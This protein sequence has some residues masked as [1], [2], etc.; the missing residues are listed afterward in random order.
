MSSSRTLRIATTIVLLMA[1]CGS[2]HVVPKPVSPSASPTANQTTIPRKDAFFGLHFDLHATKTDT[3][4]GADTSE[5]NIGRLLDRVRPDFVEYDCKGHAGYTGYP[6]KVGWASPGIVK[7]A[8]AIWRK[9][10]RERH[11]GLYIH[12]SGVWD[13]Q[14]VEEHPEW[15][16][17]DEN[18][19][20]DGKATSTF[21]RYVD[22]LLI[23]QLT[24]IVKAYDIDGA[25]VDGD[26]W[27][28][29]W[30]WSK[31]A[32]EAWSQ[33]SGGKPVPHGNKDPGWDEF[34]TMQRAQFERYL[35]HWIDAIHAVKP[36][37]QLTSNWM[38]SSF[39]PSPIK[40]KVDF[41][42][43]DYTPDASLDSARFEGRYLAS[44]HMPWDLMDWGF[45][46][47][48]WNEL[49]HWSRK[50]AV[51]IEQDLSAVLMQGGG[52][53]I[54]YQP[55]RSGYV[56]DGIID[57]ASEVAGFCRARQAVSHKSTTV[58]QVGILLSSDTHWDRTKQP[59]ADSGYDDLQGMLH[60]LLDSQYS[61]DVFADHA[62]PQVLRDY[63][64]V[65]LPDATRISRDLHDALLQYVRGGGKLLLEGATTASFF[66]TELGVKLA[67]PAAQAGAN[68]FI[69]SS[70][71]TGDGLWQTIQPGKAEV[72]ARRFSEL[73][74]RDPSKSTPAATVTKL[75]KGEIAAIY[76]PVGHIYAHTHHPALRRLI[77]DIGRRLFPSPGVT[78]EGSEYVDVALRRSRTGQLTVH[79]LNRLN[80]ASARHYSV[81]DTVPP[82]GPLAVRVHTPERPSSVR[83][84]PSD[85]TLEW[86]WK[87]GVVTVT[88]PRVEIHE[89]LVIQ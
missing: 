76:G 86:S 78:V 44:T 52:V 85:Q 45:A 1:G 50:T 31:P 57:I 4:L 14:A 34:R 56:P 69:G 10:T 9:V 3:S 83:L 18:G 42:S 53:Q 19:K 15:A 59:F 60:A 8:L 20:P 24:E 55:T 73:D 81:I 89:V 7:D 11:V 77:G 82:I 29:D 84:V 49:G 16:R 25:W 39:S 6:T 54:Y 61:V 21:G 74:D 67:G 2:S 35:S 41:L 26:A 13:F 64:L 87:D 75:E 33:A 47:G 5:E 36:G 88:V 58:P 71:V 51:Q 38:Y 30:D 48:D 63:P 65:V 80:A 79:L 66:E 40:A 12:Y 72:I 28:V 62:V 27:G 17:L 32:L 70:I 43:G 22:D 37:I 46:R 68:L 23:P